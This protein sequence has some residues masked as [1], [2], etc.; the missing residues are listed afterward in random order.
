MKILF[1]YTDINVRGGARS[2][3][4]GIGMVSAMLRKHGHD[5]RLHYMFGK[6]NPLPLQQAVL[7]WQPDVI[8]F[9]AVSPQYPYVRKALAALPETKAVAILGGIHSTLMPECITENPRLDAV[10][11]GEGEYPA[12]ELVQALEK[13]QPYDSIRNLWVRRKDGTIAHNPTRPFM[14]DLDS[15]PFPDRELFDYQEIIRTDFDLALFMFS[16]GCPYRCTFC[17]NHALREKQEGPYVRFRSVA[18]C[19]EEIRQVTTRYKAGALYFND[20]CFTAKQDWMKEFCSTYKKE[21]TLPFDINARPETLTDEVCRMLKD[22]GCRRVSIGIENGSEQ[23]RRD[24]LNRKQTN[25]QIAAGFDACKR[26][27]LK[28]KSFNIVGFPHETP[29]IHQ[30]TVDLNARINPDSVII[31]IFEPYPGT[32]LAEL[33]QA[34]NLIDTSRTGEE[35]IGR[36]DTIL[37]MPQFPRK[38]ILRCFRTFAYNVYKGHSLRKALMLRLY[39]SPYGEFLLKLVAPFKSLLRRFTMGV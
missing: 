13:G 21:F 16:R 10:C 35:F 8:A 32:K 9:S 25:D 6:F 33:C 28:T 18:N 36:T 4:F 1:V 34:E 19:M 12:L 23:F 27:G 24:I 3:Q 30:E 5:C 17:S 37:N 31:G 2:F 29:A 7:T 22:A 20:D 14:E 26:A 15:L 39:Y 38:E 11:V